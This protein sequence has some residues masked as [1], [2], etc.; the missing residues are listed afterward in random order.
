[1]ANLN[2]AALLH[3][4]KFDAHVR[5]NGIEVEIRQPQAKAAAANDVAKIM[6]SKSRETEPGES[7]TVTAL[8]LH[9]G[10]TGN[11]A[12]GSVVDNTKPL[13]RLRDVERVLKVSL[14]DALLDTSKPYGKTYFDTAFDVVI[15]DTRFKV[16]GTDTTGFPGIDPY[17]LWVGLKTI[18]ESV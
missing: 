13:G 11:L 4:Q 16:L 10:S 6:G 9:P 1:M 8:Y 12:Y 15:N 2:K 17:V 18:G 5:D 7:V 14:A 3:K